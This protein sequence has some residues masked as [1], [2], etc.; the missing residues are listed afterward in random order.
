MEAI[1][2]MWSSPDCV[3]PAHM[4]PSADMATAANFTSDFTSRVDRFDAKDKTRTSVRS[5]TVSVEASARNLSTRMKS[6]PLAGVVSAMARRAQGHG[7]A[8]HASRL[9]S[10]IVPEGCRARVP[11]DRRR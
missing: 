6:P 3:P 2:E 8:M 4:S 10:K 7:S 1:R 11:S 5:A 9:S